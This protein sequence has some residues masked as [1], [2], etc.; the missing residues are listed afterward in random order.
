MQI[1]KV[2]HLH[3]EEA[4]KTPNTKHKYIITEKIDGWYVYCDYDRFSGWS[5]IYSSANR[6]IPSMEHCFQKYFSKLPNPSSNCRLV[7]EAYIPDTCFYIL[8]G[9]FNRSVDAYDALDVHFKVH[10]II[11]FDDL[12]KTAITRYEHLFTLEDQG[13]FS[14]A[15]RI[16][17][18]SILD[19]SSER[20]DWLRIFDTVTYG[21]GEGII[22]KQTDGLYCAGKRNSS[23]MKIKLE[24]ELDLLCV[25][26]Y[27]TFG[28]KGNRNLNIKLV[29]K[30]GIEINVRVGR[31]EDIDNIDA[32]NN[33]IVGKVCVIKCMKINADGTLREPRFIAISEHKTKEEID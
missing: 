31:H 26:A 9:I 13:F 25:G 27:E 14:K 19:I 17:V 15:D 11:Y 3:L 33:Y 4:K 32:D 22:L 20:K 23:L 7:M 24:K 30:A 29:T 10:D 8:N 1:Q 12:I 21:G 16:D 18:L 6:I 28:D 2:K 5:N